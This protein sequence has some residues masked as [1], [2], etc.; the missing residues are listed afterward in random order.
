MSELDS[1]SGSVIVGK[2]A[3]LDW[4]CAWLYHL[5]VSLDHMFERSTTGCGIAALGEC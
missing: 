5:V 1:S 4:D 3:T 2:D